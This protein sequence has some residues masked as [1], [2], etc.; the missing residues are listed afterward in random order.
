[1]QSRNRNKKY[2]ELTVN[3]GVNQC[4]DSIRLQETALKEEGSYGNSCEDPWRNAHTHEFLEQKFASVW[5][6]HAADV[7]F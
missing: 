5:D 7:L 2:S 6:F 3:K 4:R 1:M